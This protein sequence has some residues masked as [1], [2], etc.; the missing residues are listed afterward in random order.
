MTIEAQ[1]AAQAPD[2]LAEIGSRFEA[3]IARL[4]RKVAALTIALHRTHVRIEAED[5]DDD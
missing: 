5:D 3:R 2:I 1:R 4:E